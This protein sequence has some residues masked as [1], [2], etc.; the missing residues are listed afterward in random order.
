MA[1][2]MSM[3]GKVLILVGL[4]LGLGLVLAFGARANPS[5]A[6]A[7]ECSPGPCQAWDGT[8]QPAGTV[9]NV[10]QWDAAIPWTSPGPR[11]KGTYKL[12]G[13]SGQKMYAPKAPTPEAPPKTT[14]G[15]GT[16][17]YSLDD[18]VAAMKAKGLLAK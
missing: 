16:T 1:S 11:F 2:A 9:V 14:G 15:T 4:A 17:G 10:I 5:S 8:M 13:F 6:Y 12:V 3:V 7:V 18:I